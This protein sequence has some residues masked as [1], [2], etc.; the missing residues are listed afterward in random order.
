MRTLLITLG[1]AGTLF[2]QPVLAGRDAYQEL[3]TRQA[4]EAKRAQAA[5]EAKLN[6]CA[7]A[8]RTSTAAK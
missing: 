2:G 4:H 5:Q 7:E 6:Q 8:Q 3:L 1:L